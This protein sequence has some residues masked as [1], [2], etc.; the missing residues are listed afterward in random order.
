MGLLLLELCTPRAGELEVLRAL[1]KALRIGVGVVNQ[2]LGEIESTDSIVERIRR[3]VGLF[4]AERVVLT[5]D[6]GFSTFADT[7]LA[8]STIAEA[9]LSRIVEAAQIFLGR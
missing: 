7:P 8:D 3:A 6:C 1:P 2:K 4:G 5:P 9:K